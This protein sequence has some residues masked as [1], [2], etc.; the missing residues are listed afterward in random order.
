MYVVQTVW[1]VTRG[2]T[3]YKYDGLVH[4][5]V[6]KSRIGMFLVQQEA[7]KEKKFFSFIKQ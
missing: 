1:D 7:K 4:T 2:V 6:F 5:S 3:V